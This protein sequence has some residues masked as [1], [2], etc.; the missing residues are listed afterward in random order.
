[1]LIDFFNKLREAK[2][3]V[4][5]TEFLSLL[6]AMD[7]HVASNS[8]DDFYYLS[9]AALVKDERHYDR[10]DKVFGAYFKGME[11]LF[12]EVIGEIPEDWLRK[13]MELMLTEE[14]KRQIESMGGWE[15]LMETLR[16][17][18]EEQKERHQ[19]ATSGSARAALRRS[20]LMVTIPKVS[21]SGRTDHAT[22]G[23]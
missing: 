17:R 8:V 6:N 19:G 21:V 11:E 2:I 4:S 5:V 15:E 1:M 12:N 18:L 13:Q 16:K 9:R 7:K 22:G 23:R 14:E 20:E 3:P 10:F